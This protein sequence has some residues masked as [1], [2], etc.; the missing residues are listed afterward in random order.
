MLTG[1]GSLDRRCLA[2][3]SAVMDMWPLSPS[4]VAQ[5]GCEREFTMIKIY[6]NLNSHT[7]LVATILDN[8]GLKRRSADSTCSANTE[9]W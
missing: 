9:H 7:Y 2:E 1:G 8:T 5:C 4:R 3:L 6:L